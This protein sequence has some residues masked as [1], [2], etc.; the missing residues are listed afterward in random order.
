MILKY[1]TRAAR[2]ASRARQL[3]RPGGGLAGTRVTLNVQ[4]LYRDFVIYLSTSR[5]PREPLPLLL[6]ACLLLLL[7]LLLL[8]ILFFQIAAPQI[9]R[10]LCF[11]FLYNLIFPPPFP[12]L[13]N[14][15][16]NNLNP[17]QIQTINHFQNKNVQ[18][19]SLQ[20]PSRVWLRRRRPPC[21]G[22]TTKVV[23]SRTATSFSTGPLFRIKCYP[24]PLTVFLSTETEA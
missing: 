16:A 15:D 9:I 5:G 19:L 4:E 2:A 22:A 3:Q 21:D 10:V 8:H 24:K 6:A 23:I 18:V 12:P 1:R 11:C 13:A 20:A 14:L 17:L 7:L